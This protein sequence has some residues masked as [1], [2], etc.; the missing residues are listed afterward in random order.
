M[1]ALGCIAIGKNMKINFVHKTRR[2][3]IPLGRADSYCST[4]KLWLIF[5]R[6][7]ILHEYNLW[8]KCEVGIVMR[9]AGIVYLTGIK[10]TF[11]K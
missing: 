2:R 8:G 4:G 9:C 10:K 7:Y 1:H 6:K 5:V 3:L 11:S